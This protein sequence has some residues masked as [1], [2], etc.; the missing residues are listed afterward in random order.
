ML[1]GA[2]LPT[3]LAPGYYSLTVIISDPVSGAQTTGT[4]PMWVG[5]E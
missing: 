1:L 3:G 5:D 2:E 4:M